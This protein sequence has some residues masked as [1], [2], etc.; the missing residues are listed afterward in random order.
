MT[1]VEIFRNIRYAQADRFESPELLPW[2]GVRH[3]ERGPVCPQAPSRLESVQGPLAPLEQDEHCQVLSVF[4]PATTGKRPVMVFIHGGGFVT[5]GGELPWHDGDQL[6]AEQDIVVV[7]VTYRLGVFGYYQFPKSS[8]P[9]LAMADQVAALRW[10][11]A[12]IAEFGGDADRVTVFGQSAGGFSIVAMLAWGHGG[13]LFQRAIVHSGANGMARTRGEGE[14]ISQLFLDELGQDP[15]T[16]SLDAILAAQS[17][18]A[19]TLNQLAV[20]APISPD[21]PIGSAVDL[22]AGWCKDD[23]LPF[24]LLQQHV[25]AVPGTESRFADATREMNVLFEGGSRSLVQNIL[26]QGKRASL[27]RFDWQSGSSGLGACHCIDLPFLL[28]GA[29]AWRSAPA[30]AGA[31]WAEIDAIGKRMRRV[32][33]DFARGESGE[34]PIDGVRLLPQAL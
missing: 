21:T 12:H 20:W 28:G 9:S 25:A 18:L 27:F 17:R 23:A 32:W 7:S 31:A 29:E 34:W 26:A 14:R 15:R 10:I 19:A 4:T 30:L 16:A 5:G 11:K 3:R 13:T 33:A 8:G 24:V 6:A 2:D 22:L 1:H